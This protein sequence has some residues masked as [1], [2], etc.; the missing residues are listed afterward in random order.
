[1]TTEEG[2]PE[3]HRDSQVR[4]HRR[5]RQALHQRVQFQRKNVV[6][7]F[8]VGPVVAGGAGHA[9]GALRRDG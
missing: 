2:P 3:Q 5:P 8:P 4:P 1:M 6:A 7:E 9:S